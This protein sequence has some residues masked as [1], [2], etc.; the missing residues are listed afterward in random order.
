ML[1]R[2]GRRTR[3]GSPAPRRVVLRRGGAVRVDVIDVVGIDAPVGERGRD[4]RR[5]RPPFGLRRRRMERFARE[6]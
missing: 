1:R 6:L 2:S 5:D 4:D 3:A